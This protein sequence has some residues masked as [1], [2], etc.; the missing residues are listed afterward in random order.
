MP[1]KRT[2]SFSLV[3]FYGLGT[4]IG[5]GIYALIG[6][7]VHKA[8]MYTPFAFLIAGLVALFTATSY[9]EL[10]SRFPESAGSALYIKK[11]LNKTWLSAL[12]GWLVVL[13]G[14]VSAATL[15][16]GFINYIHLF[17]P[18][19]SY[20]ILLLLI[21]IL[22]VIAFWGIT[23]SVGTILVMTIVEILGLLIII[24]FGREGFSKI[25]V[26]WHQYLPPLNFGS[27]SGILSG[28]F[29][30]FYAFIGFEDM[31]NIAEETKKPEI[32][33]PLAI[34][35]ALFF[36]IFLYIIVAGVTIST[37]P[38]QELI[39]SEIPLT[40][41]IKH[42][43]H[44]P[45]LFGIIALISITNGILIQ[46]IMA[47]RL[48]YGMARYRSAPHFFYTLHKKTQTP[49]YAIMVIVVAIFILAL[50]LPIDTLARTTSTIMLVVFSLVNLSLIIIKLKKYKSKIPI[51]FPIIFPFIGLF[52]TLTLLIFEII[53]I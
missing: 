42:Q 35:F 24:W 53:I 33:L 11:A 29:I 23:E 36:A 49:L 22:G 9:A 25:F 51:S 10:S 47:S 20:L 5:A 6:S 21:F 45:L 7:V 1:L 16:R 26:N 14:L 50:W 28:A 18:L 15:S 43:G 27:W 37:I 38:H 34:F 3:L 2:L 41:I 8:N 13:T 31:V 44:S 52:L 17:L 39:A 32:T 19:P 12:V 30:A 48:I 4:I 40:L 46:I